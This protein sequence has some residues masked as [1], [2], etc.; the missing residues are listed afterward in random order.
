MAYSTLP[1]PTHS[2]PSQQLKQDLLSQLGTPEKTGERRE[3][4]DLT[5]TLLEHV[6]KLKMEL[7]SVKEEN[8]RL[9]NV[10]S[11]MDNEIHELTEN[12]FEEAYKMVDEAKGGK[13]S[14]EKRLA[15]AAGKMDAMETE[16]STLKRIMQSSQ[17]PPQARSVSKTTGASLNT[18][19]LPQSHSPSQK[20]IKRSSIKRA[21]HKIQK[22]TG[23]AAPKSPSTSA[24]RLP[25]IQPLIDQEEYAQFHRWIKSLSLSSPLSPS[26]PSTPTPTS[27]SS[28][29]T[30]LTS[31][32]DQDV[33]PCLS[34]KNTELSQRVLQAVQ[35][36]YVTMEALQTSTSSNGHPGHVRS[37]SLP[38][39]GVLC[40]LCEAKERDC[41]HRLRLGEAKEWL[42]ISQSCRDRVAA[43]CDFFMHISHIQ[44]GIIK[45]DS[46]SSPSDVGSLYQDSSFSADLHLVAE[47]IEDQVTCGIC[48]EPYKQPRLLKCFHVYCE[49][50]LQRLRCTEF[51]QEWEEFKTHEII[52]L[53]TLTGD[54]TT[55]VPPLKKTLFCSK[56]Q[57]TKADLYCET[58]DELI[59][60]DCI[61]R[62][63]RDHQYDLVP[64]S[65][66]KQEKVIVDSLKPVEEQIATLER[67][68]ESVDTQCA[69]V[70]EQKTAV[71]AEIRT[72]RA[73]L[74]QALEARETELVGQAEQTAQQKLK[75]L[76]AQRDGFEL[77]LGQLRSCQD[78]VEE[79]RRTCSQGEIL[80]MKS[81]LV[82]QV[83]DL[84]GS[85]KP[86][87][88]ALAEQADMVFAHSLPELMKI[89]Q[90]FGKVYCH[91][92]CPEKCR[93][94]G[95]G[96]R[97]ATRGQTVAV[98]VE[99][100]DRE[101]EAY[102]RPVD[103][104]RCELV[105]S[106]GSSRVRGTAK[107]RNRNIYDISYQPQ[108]TG[109]HQLH[110]LIEEHPILNSPFTVTV[111][112][113]FTAPANI[114][115]GLDMPWGI[116]VREGGEV[117]VAEYG[118][119]CVS[120]ISGNGEKKS[121]GT[122]GSGPG[123]FNSPEGIAIDNGGSILV[124]DFSN[125]RIQQLSSTGKHLR[126][127]GTRGSGPL[128]FQD[129]AGIT[130]HPHT[131]K[132]YVAD[133]DNHR[134]QVLNSDLTY[135]SSFGRKGSN[136]GEFNEPYD[137]ST[138]R[139]GNV[140]VADSDNHRIQVFTG[141]GVYLR[142]F[143]KKGEGEGELN[144]P[145]S[146]AID[147]AN[148]VYVGEL[149]TIVYQYSLLMESLSSHLE[150][151]EKQL[152]QDLLSQLGTP[153]K[154][155][156]RRE[157]EDLTKTLL[158]HVVKLKMELASV[159]EENERLQNVRS[160]M[161][162][163]IHELTE[164]LFEEAYKMVDEAKGGKVSAEKRLA[165]AAGKI[166]AMETEM[167]TL[168][169]IMQSSQNPPQARSVS[170]T[171]GASLNTLHLP[172]SHSPSQK[173]IK[174]SSIKRAVHKI[175][176]R[177]GL[178][179][180]KSPSTSASRLP[181]IQPLIDQ[182]EY[183]QFH[184]WIKSLSLSSPLSPSSPSTP[185]PTSSSSPHTYL[186]SIIDQDVR[187]C[188]SFKNTELSQRV[189]QAVQ[190]NYVTMEALQT[191]TS[192]NGHP[193][194]VRSS[195]LPPEGV[196]CAL[197]EAKERDCTHRLR[198]GEAKEWLYISQ[199]CRDRVA[200]VCDFFMHISHIQK[201]IIKADTTKLY[202][203]VARLRGLMQLSRYS[204]SLP[205]DLPQT[206]Q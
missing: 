151:R 12:L 43:V 22:R 47:K 96:I 122:H 206:P 147:S 89:C 180:P 155:G 105:A 99:A 62:V 172:Q 187:P 29:H 192:S 2:S 53:D 109:E 64:E 143:G 83:N 194:H 80:R 24:S 27:S 123:Q 5:K 75:T 140:Y 198:L 157:G 41:T 204:L 34:F 183:A 114:I 37:S 92:V 116:A 81:P 205:P 111:L 184:R 129:P 58:C 67:A 113:N 36:N 101:G 196:L 120:I 50:C 128:Q 171:T 203:E 145:V 125:H 65:F 21:V 32:I 149:G 52:D 130:V 201:G 25:P 182:E 173:H 11:N 134:I 164:N 177:T 133:C 188:L 131:G 126:T 103:S 95:K 150:E 132:V 88:L 160:N 108:V 61:V 69:A 165:D 193:G 178:A 202:W 141:D 42:Y 45:A 59:C 170:K 189:L 28:P 18:L 142:Q 163:E 87:T 72:A 117:V 57:E 176:K 127:V 66:A 31:I 40:A 76:A 19:H 107:R 98:S 112:S 20:H 85:F 153:E 102:L 154:T 63:H 159:K 110:I 197:C 119:E 79:S 191:S 10:R 26:S 82:K 7:A 136:N 104:L 156:E 86:E 71:V 1:S 14:A 84:T 195:S 39:E 35:D 73:H 139:E 51:H 121:F 46:H 6:V 91:L 49:Q 162:N 124:A 70:V 48:L 4:E 161:D 38:P 30:Y 148:V 8:E 167:S 60:R 74:R 90:Q 78:F 186:T 56:H 144:G 138:D 97:V 68:V 200:A 77:Q 54:V 190:D 23:L 17:N 158:E 106:D 181:P 9:Q 169:R 44:K 15:D 146:I 185:T 93:A 135:S 174:R 179:A 13:V 199:S 115:R 16:M 118:G 152:K 94:S 100:L 168:K 3:G 33:R 166:D 55:L 175:Q 137:I